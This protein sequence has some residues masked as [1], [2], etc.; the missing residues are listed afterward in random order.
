MPIERTEPDPLPLARANPT[1]LRPISNEQL[2]ALVLPFSG[3]SVAQTYRGPAWV[4]DD[5]IGCLVFI[6]TDE[7]KVRLLREERGCGVLAWRWDNTPS[8]YLSLTLLQRRQTTGSHVRWMGPS[9]DPVIQA[10]RRNGR[11]LMTVVGPRGEHGGWHEA[12]FND[13]AAPG[14]SSSFAAFERLWEFT[15]AGIPY[16]CIRERYVPFPEEPLDE[17]ED[18]EIPLWADATADF[19]RTLNYEGPWAPDLTPLDKA[20][21]EWGY[22]AWHRRHRAAGFIQILRDRV[23]LDGESTLFNSS[24]QLVE[25]GE[26]ADRVHQLVSRYPLLGDWLVALAGPDANAKEAHS[27]AFAALSD[28]RTVFAMLDKLFGILADIDSEALSMAWQ[29]S[30]EGAL[31]DPRI[32]K[33]GTRRPWL[34]NTKEYAIDVKSMLIDVTAPLADITRLWRSGIEIIDLVDAGLYLNPSDFPAPLDTICDAFE[35]VAI[36][37]SIEDAEDRLEMLLLEAQE[38]RQWSIP[39]G[40]RV[41]IRFG[42]FVALK[43]FESDGEFTCYFLDD[44]DRYFHVAIGLRQHPP[45]SRTHQLIRHRAD[46]GEAVWNEDAVISLKLIAGAIIR[47]F[48]VVEERESLFNARPMRRRIRGRDIRTVIYLPRV[49]YTTPKLE[50]A[51]PE[52]DVGLRPKHNVGAHLR[53]AKVASPAQRFLAQRY[54]WQVPE[55]FTFVRPHARGSELDAARVK[56]YRSR[57]ASRMLFEQ[58]DQAP[59]GT[60]PAW[61]DFEKDC[62]RILRA[63]GMRVIHQGAQRDG[64]GGVDLFAVDGEDQS[65]VV[66]CKCWATHRPVGPE[67]LRELQGA[68]SLTDKGAKQPSKGMVITTSI[69]TSGAVSTGAELGFELVDGAQLAQMLAAL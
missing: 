54:G 52:T 7:R 51:A 39:W 48:L 35:S 26:L 15:R 9:E 56:V 69:F 57:S 65:W 40:A 14:A 24:S 28:S 19:W 6:A 20:M 30:F 10:I 49:R 46:D 59:A 42:P 25:A 41:D 62:A 67:V 13:A 44:C 58:I 55:G 4:T 27:A 43:I 11:F 37:G 23:R 3:K 64:D 63:R 29:F 18:E 53:R 68:I 66:Q 34:A 5:G 60:R 61:F 47:D 45:A 32:T 1:N 16:S 22:H 38:A 17:T 8:M 2:S 36:E 33:E 50:R 12:V 21:A 31:L